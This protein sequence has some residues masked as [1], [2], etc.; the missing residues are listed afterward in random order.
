MDFQID[1]LGERRSVDV[2]RP[3]WLDW[4]VRTPTFCVDIFFTDF[5]FV[6]VSACLFDARS[7]RIGSVGR[8][9]VAFLFFFSL[10]RAIGIQ[11]E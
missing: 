9:N 4:L 8:N 2:G 3:V 6:R 1:P 11:L 10:F 7:I 5:I